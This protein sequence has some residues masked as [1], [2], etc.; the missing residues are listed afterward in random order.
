MQATAETTI[1]R[2]RVKNPDA[3]AYVMAN[4]ARA[5]GEAS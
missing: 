1:E 3:I 4:P 2:C 5:V